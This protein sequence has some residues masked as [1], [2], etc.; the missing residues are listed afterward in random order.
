MTLQQRTSFPSCSI[1]PVSPVSPRSSRNYEICGKADKRHVH[2]RIVADHQ[3]L[4]LCGVRAL[5][6]YLYLIGWKGG[7]I[8]PKEKE[9]HK[10]PR[11]GIY[12]TTIDYEKFN[13]D[14]QKL[15]KKVL[16][17]RDDL[18]I[19]CQT[20]QKTGYAMA[21]FGNANREDL[22][23]S[24][25]H[26]QKSKDAPTY[27]KVREAFESTKSPQQCKRLVQQ[28]ALQKLELI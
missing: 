1:F 3:Y 17:A 13:K 22:T 27:S 23:M 10:P 11:D 16:I 4:E 2:L 18:K 7:S 12:T 26:S 6:V 8:F 15:C 20:F 19:G 28:L 5:L 25:R 14:L 9:L 21:I 24:A